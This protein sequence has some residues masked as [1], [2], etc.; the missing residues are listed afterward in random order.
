MRRCGPAALHQRCHRGLALVPLASRLH[1]L[2][3]AWPV[4]LR[5]CGVFVPSTCFLPPPHTTVSTPVHHAISI[6]IQHGF[7]FVWLLVRCCSEM[8][9]DGD[10]MIFCC[11]IIV[12]LSEEHTQCRELV[13]KSCLT[14]LDF[15]FVRFY[16]VLNTD[17]TSWTCSCF[18]AWLPEVP[19]LL[20]LFGVS[21][22]ISPLWLVLYPFSVLHSKP[23][24]IWQKKTPN[25]LFFW[26]FKF[27]LFHTFLTPDQQLKY[28]ILISEPSDP[29]CHVHVM[30]QCIIYFIQNSCIFWIWNIFDMP[31]TLH[32]SH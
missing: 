10:S 19:K 18:K 26:L 16:N 32:T 4:C 31:P 6:F 24:K 13:S 17:R 21:V 5:L 29:F 25:C 11:I 7:K 2:P 9:L 28:C 20:F 27:S 8:K 3:G 14:W 1:H 12:Q 30:H 22:V 23:Y 15:L